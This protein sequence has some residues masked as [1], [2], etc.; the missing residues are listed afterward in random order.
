MIP[1]LRILSFTLVLLTINSLL[2]VGY[3]VSPEKNEVKKESKSEKVN[4]IQQLEVDEKF[5]PP[6]P[7][8]EEPYMYL[9]PKE[10][11]GV[12]L[13]L[14]YNITEST[15]ENSIGGN[16]SKELKKISLITGIDVSTNGNGSWYLAHRNYSYWTRAFRFHNK[17]GFSNRI[18]SEDGLASILRYSNYSLL[19]NIGLERVFI[20]PVSYQLD[21]DLHIGS[22]SYVILKF[23]YSWAQ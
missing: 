4:S 22:N 5:P 14:S 3:E 12:N 11:L 1:Y 6:P 15:Q 20:N 23:G 10:S 17:I 13:G 8:I 16:Y 19:L 21:L 18:R 7:H 9:T 2:A